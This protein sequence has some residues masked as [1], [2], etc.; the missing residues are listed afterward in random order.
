M[1]G[2]RK[3]GLTG[4]QLK[5]STSL[6]AKY[7]N[8]DLSGLD[9]TKCNLTGISFSGSNLSRTN[10]AGADLRYADFTNTN[11]DGAIFSRDTYFFK[12]KFPR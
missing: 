8:L 9:Y 1:A 4:R 2:A 11:L 10:F 3:L 7:R 6:K 12:T 5:V